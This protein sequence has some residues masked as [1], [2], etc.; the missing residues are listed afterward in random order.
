VARAAPEPTPADL[1]T[2]VYLTEI[3]ASLPVKPGE[4]G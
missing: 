4:R 1:L 3:S 2:D